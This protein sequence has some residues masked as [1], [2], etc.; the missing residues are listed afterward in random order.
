[1]G[2]LWIVHSHSG[3][4]RELVIMKNNVKYKSNMNL[5]CLP[6]IT[7]GTWWE[8]VVFIQAGNFTLIISYLEKWKRKL[9]RQ[10]LNP[11]L[12]WPSSKI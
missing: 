6:L 4:C 1:M 5:S 2:E 3:H 11:S 7:G 10:I 8:C 12:P 9:Y